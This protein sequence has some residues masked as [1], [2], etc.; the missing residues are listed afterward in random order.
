MGGY[1]Q[2]KVGTGRSRAKPR[3]SL[4]SKRK[5]RPW[6]PKLPGIYMLKHLPTEAAYVGQSVDIGRRYKQHIGALLGHPYGN[7]KLH[8]NSYLR[9]AFNAYD[10][11][12]WAFI[13]L[14]LLPK[15]CTKAQLLK[16]EKHYIQLYG[17]LNVAGRKLAE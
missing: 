4:R 14:E 16:R 2:S 6:E 17:T 5:A 12:E 7:T 8:H 11:H 10:V 13:I 3:A 9:A 15:D 1:S